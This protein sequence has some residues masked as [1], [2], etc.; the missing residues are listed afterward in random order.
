MWRALVR[1]ASRYGREE[2]A[3]LAAVLIVGRR[4]H[5]RDRHADSARLAH[6]HRQ[7][8]VPALFVGL[9]HAARCEQRQCARRHRIE[10]H[11]PFVKER[12]LRPIHGAG[13][14][15]ARQ[16]AIEL[17][18]AL[19]LAPSILSC[20]APRHRNGGIRH[21]DGCQLGHWL[22]AVMAARAA[23]DWKPESV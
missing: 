16:T 5:H 2:Q 8:V 1:G 6:F 21:R 22:G 14:R 7:R 23:T 11:L 17:H 12:H 13:A 10:R 9:L 3:E 4:V 18:P 15:L 20:T 19:T